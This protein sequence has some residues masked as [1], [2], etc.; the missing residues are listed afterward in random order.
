[1]VS[2]NVCELGF[3]VF[4]KPDQDRKLRHANNTIHRS[5]SSVELNKSGNHGCGF[6]AMLLN[7]VRTLEKNGGLIDLTELSADQ[8]DFGISLEELGKEGRGSQSLQASLR[9]NLGGKSKEFN[10]EFFT[11]PNGSLTSLCR[12]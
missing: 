11:S 1:M 8:V 7:G 4:P 10:I 5:I 3:Q 9:Y 6:C 2:C 12:L